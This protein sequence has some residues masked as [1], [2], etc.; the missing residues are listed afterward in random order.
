[1]PLLQ[2]STAK[3]VSHFGKKHPKGGRG[4]KNLVDAVDLDDVLTWCYVGDV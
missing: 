1:M 2:S 3:I 4:V